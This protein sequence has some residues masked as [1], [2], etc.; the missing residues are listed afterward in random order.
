MLRMT[1]GHRF[2]GRKGIAMALDKE[3][4]TYKANLPTL[5]AEEGTFALVLGADLEVFRTYDDAIGAGYSR[6]GLRPFL[7]KRIQAFERAQFIPRL[8]A[9]VS[10]PR[11]RMP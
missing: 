11:P 1:R 10:A 8:F 7:V 6:Y 2:Y 3:L 9:R 5:N 4:E